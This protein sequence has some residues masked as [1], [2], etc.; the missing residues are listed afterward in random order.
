[1][2][3]RP[4]RHGLS[5]R[6]RR[7][8]ADHGRR[9]GREG[10]VASS[11]DGWNEAARRRLRVRSRRCSRDGTARR[12]MRRSSTL[13]SSTLW[14]LLSSARLRARHDD[15]AGRPFDTN[16]FRGRGP[17]RLDSLCSWRRS[18]SGC[19]P[20]RSTVGSDGSLFVGGCSLLELAARFGTPLFVYDVEHIR[21]RC[22]EAVAA[23]GAGRVIYATKAFLCRAVARLIHD[24]GLLFDVASG[25]ELHVVLSA[26]VPAASCIMHG[27]NKSID[28][29]RF[30]GHRRRATDRRRQLR[31]TRSSRLIAR[32]SGLAI[33]NV[34]LR[35]TP[36]G[37]CP[38][39]HLHRHRPERLQV[40]LQSRQ[41]GRRAGRPAGAG[42]TVGQPRR[43]PLPYRVERLRRRQLRQ[44]GGGDGRASRPASSCRSSSS[45]VGSVLP[46]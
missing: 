2:R 38:H 37:P 32:V 45:V 19:C 31:R 35:V 8:D 23:F 30:G 29:L 21:T 18:S 12:S 13:Q 6:G 16:E 34:L 1:M 36:G 3:R 22:R 28:E 24:E 11:G 44:G 15:V 20:T 40:R 33:P 10:G 27:N 7:G 26:G 39:P 43:V 4:G 17:R 14:C 42:V 25:G 41:R 5:D 9:D 46:M